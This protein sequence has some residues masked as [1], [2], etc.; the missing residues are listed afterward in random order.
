MTRFTLWVAIG[1]C[2][3]ARV[4]GDGGPY[5]PGPASPGS[6]AIPADSVL[7]KS[8]ARSMASFEA[9]PRR[10]GADSSS[11]NYGSIDS[12][13]GP[14]DAA[15]SE[16]DMP[17][18]EGPVLSLGDGGRVTL[19]FSPPIAD[20]EGADFAVFENGFAVGSSG[21]FAELAFVEVSSNG[22]D[23]VRFP[24][25]SCTPT[26][27]QTGSFTTL[28]P[29][30]LHN[31]AGKHPAGYGTPFDLSELVAANPALNAARITHVRI[32]DVV[33]D[34]TGGLGSRDSNGNWINDPFPTDFQTCGFDLDAVGVIHQA[35]DGWQEWVAASFEP[36]VQND[37]A[38]TGPDADP[39]GDGKTNL[40]EYA[41]GFQPAAA[42][43]EAALTV[44]SVQSLV[45]LQFSRDA[46]RSEV[47]LI[48]QDSPDGL[49]WSTLASSTGGGATTGTGVEIVESGSPRTI[50]SVTA[51]R[52]EAKR[53]YRLKVTR[54]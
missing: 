20:G 5:P 16:Y 50:V 4:R 12:V 36:A 11:A 1:A 52:T 14:P 46:A 32:V 23:F 54:G 31:L 13:F 48:L 49:A 40:I 21:I 53:F 33:G 38:I 9:G 30:N 29:R 10:A 2:A 39:E 3:V 27:A 19:Q 51:P 17:P 15:G 26:A 44:S 22:V 37:P 28:D 24:A 34:V 41:C 8:W 25:V 43:G 6:D 35:Q 7:F 47:S 42:E 18:E 45:V